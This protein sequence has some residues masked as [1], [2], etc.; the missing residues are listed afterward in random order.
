LH[1]VTPERLSVLELRSV[2][3]TG[4]GPEKTILYGAEQRDRAHFDVTVCYIR[5]VRDQVFGIDRRAGDLGVDYVE[6]RERHSFDWR[7]WHALRDLI[8][9]RRVDIVHAHEY[10]TDVLAYLLAR[11]TGVA[12]LSTAH[13]WTGHSARERFVYY[14]FDKRLLA[15][16][17]RVIAVSS[18]I[19]HELQRHGVKADRIRVILNAIDPT[20]FRR[21]QR[22]TEVRRGLGLDENAVVVGSV[23]RLEP[24]KRFDL[25]IE[26]VHGL[27][28]GWPS[29]HVVIAG[30]GSRRQA[31]VDQ[32]TRLGFGH[33]CRFLGHRDDVVDL[34]EAFDV[35]VQSSDYEGTPNAVLEAMA[36]ETPFVA[37]DAGG[38]G[39]LAQDGV[40]GMIV[41]PGDVFR[42]R[43]A[44]E[45]ILANPTEARRRAIQ[46]RARVETELSFDARTRHLEAVYT[47]LAGLNRGTPHA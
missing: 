18:E 14:P 40:H 9:A 27:M 47:E 25:L 19:K 6:I 45:A 33:R 41:P 39:E 34:H 17:P 36:M 24:Q 22:R 35:F 42:L 26:A 46:A 20:R 13:G 15:R 37:T 29:L 1:P 30:E 44:I 5:D 21:C 32:S 16:F 28:A 11:Q 4:G 8:Q 23:G 38:T 2:R 10:K 12:A 31:L 3:G 43:A 7:I